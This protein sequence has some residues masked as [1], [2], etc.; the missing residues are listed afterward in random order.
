MS[1][2]FAL[3]CPE[4]GVSFED[5]PDDAAH[6]TDAADDAAAPDFAPDAY[7]CVACTCAFV[8]RFG[9]AFAVPHPTGRGAA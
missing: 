3:V 5:Q 8:V 9:Y 6:A 2:I 1:G 4:C 7:V